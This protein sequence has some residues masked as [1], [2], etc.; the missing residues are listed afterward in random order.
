[1]RAVILAAGRGGRLRDVTGTAPKCLARIG[2]ATLIERQIEALRRAGV[3]DITVVA[4]H[5]LDQVR[6]VCGA[7][8][9]IVHNARFAATNS[10]YSLWLARDLLGDGFIVLNCDVLFHQ[11]LLDDL[12]TARYPDALLVAAAATSVTPTRR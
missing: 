12:L 6:R 2:A 9:H 7:G 1:M 8:V 3:N 5:R 10:L 11:Q 4:G